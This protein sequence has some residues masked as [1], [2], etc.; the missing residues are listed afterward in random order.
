M[1]KQ[2]LPR[3]F[4]ITEQWGGLGD[5]LAYSTLPESFFRYFGKKTYVSNFYNARN[6]E[7]A[8]LVWGCNPY[9]V[10]W[11]SQAPNAGSAVAYE[12]LEGQTFIENVET[13]HGLPAMNT[14][15]KVYY[16][17][18]Q[19]PILRDKFLIDLSATT[20]SRGPYY[21]S[22]AILERKV[23]QLI[24]TYGSRNVNFVQHVNLRSVD[25]HS[26]GVT[27]PLEDK[28]TAIPRLPVNSIF[29][30]ADALSSARGL[31]GLHSGAVAL[32]AAIREFN[33]D[34]DIECLIAPGLAVHPRQLVEKIHNYPDVRYTPVA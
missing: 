3:E 11:S 7:I 19:N 21:L 28:F 29:E 6:A 14:R 31:I 27:T 15:P 10:G 16:Q 9:V 2:Q 30:F 18:K 32:A 23:A 22:P 20:L 24:D 34:L 4:V 13:S 25:T 26:L 5:A 1:R 12:W 17:P 8:R 33:S